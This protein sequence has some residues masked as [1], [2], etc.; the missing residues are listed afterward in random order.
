M[1][2]KKILPVVSCGL[3]LAAGAAGGAPTA[4]QDHARMME[5]LHIPSLRQGV[6]GMDM[7]APNAVNYDEAR[8]RTYALP[9]PLRLNDGRAVKTAAQWWKLRRPQIVEAFDRD[10]YGRLPAKIPSV[11]WELRGAEKKKVGPYDA[12]TEHVVGHVDNSAH[13]S[14][15]VDIAMDVT[16]PAAV[17]QSVP[18]MIALVWT[19]KWAN[20]P[21]PA[22]QGPDWREQ[23]L[24]LGWGYAELVPTTIQPDDGA[25][26][27][28][29]II[30]LANKGRPRKPDDWGALRAWAWGTSR[31]V[32]YL[33]RDRS[34]D[35][36]RIGVEGHSRYG[37]AALV[38]MATDPRIAVGYISSSGAGGAKLLRRNYGEQ[39]EN[40]AGGEYYWMAGNF[41]KYAGPKT[42]DDLPVD[43][44]DLIALC[45]PRPVFIGAGTMEAGDGWVDARGSFLAAAA[46]GPVYELLGKKGLGTNELPPVGT[47][48]IS[49]GLGFRQHPFGH[50]PQPN[51]ATFLEFAKQHFR[52]E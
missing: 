6:N 48:L 21:I 51:W 3:L 22:G 18:V 27:F 9:D 15:S 36:A 24:A 10:V 43:A 34:V 14:V 37:K 49:G 44:H 17:K 13:P 12:V 35:A 19:G 16:L 50:T 23:L 40:L 47:A 29:G 25:G 32:D 30:G 26:L 11:R 45:A 5:I 20:P 38:A 52:P 41:L 39:L 33:S 42:V 2:A 46:A 7:T 8:V 31:A 28:Q 4:E 1:I